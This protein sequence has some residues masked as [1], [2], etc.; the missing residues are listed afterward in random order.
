MGVSIDVWRQRI[1]LFTKPSSKHKS[2]LMEGYPYSFSWHGGIHVAT[3]VS[4]LFAVAV[5]SSYLHALPLRCDTIS[6][7]GDVE[8]NPG[9]FTP[10]LDDDF[11]RQLQ[12]KDPQIILPSFS[13]K[14]KHIHQLH[15]LKKS[16]NF[17]WKL[18][19]NG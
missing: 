9:P 15:E 14:N 16:N 13:L 2:L 18:L 11:L 8:L 5:A 10:M 6:S 19:L 4:I 7:C 12:I 1:G 3:F 17:S